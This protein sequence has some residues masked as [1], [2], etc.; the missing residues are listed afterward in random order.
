MLNRALSTDPL[1]GPST[2][3][4]AATHCRS[5]D[6]RTEDMRHTH[7]IIIGFH[8]HNLGLLGNWVKS[9]KSSHVHF[10]ETHN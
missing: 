3:A 8:I 4:D 1:K 5:L 7:K 6:R 10:L 2:A 9:I